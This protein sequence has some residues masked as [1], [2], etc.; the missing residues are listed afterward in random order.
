MEEKVIYLGFKIDIIGITPVKEKIENIRT[1]KEPRNV[2][3]LK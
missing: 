3:E 1:T 2:S